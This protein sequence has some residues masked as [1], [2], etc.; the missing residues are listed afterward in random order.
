VDHRTAIATF[1]TVARRTGTTAGR[2]ALSVARRAAQ[3]IAEHRTRRSSTPPRGRSPDVPAG[4]PA[5]EVVEPAPTRQRAGASPAD[6]A[7]AVARNAAGLSRTNPGPMRRQVARRS[8]PG[9]K[10]PARAGQ[11]ILGA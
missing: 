7:R 4:P 6:V 11:G 9:A 8:A 1:R 5:A 3:Q 2:T 10:L